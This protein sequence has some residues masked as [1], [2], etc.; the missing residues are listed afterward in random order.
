[1]GLYESESRTLLCPCHQS[2]FDVLDR[3]RPTSGPAAAALPQLPLSVDPSGYIVA[4][5]EFSDPVG[6]ASWFQR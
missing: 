5:G 2:V 1:V 3:A 4:A 6:P